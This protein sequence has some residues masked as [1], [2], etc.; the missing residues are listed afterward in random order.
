VV[1]NAIRLMD[2]RPSVGSVVDKSLAM[3]LSAEDPCLSY[4]S[5]SSSLS[6]APVGSEDAPSWS[7]GWEAPFEGTLAL[8][9]FER[10]VFVLTVLER[11]TD[12]DCAALLRTSRQ[13]VREGRIR[14]FRQL[15]YPE[16][17]PKWRSQL[18]S[19]WTSASRAT[20]ESP[21]AVR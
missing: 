19:E 2:P 17:Y 6:A 14:A 8:G 18:S 11:H 16:P 4:L 21:V 12:Q 1:Q 10:V 20:N 5:G 15:P 7:V 13:E 9:D 3:G